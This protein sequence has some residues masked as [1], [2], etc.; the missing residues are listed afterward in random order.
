MGKT[1]TFDPSRYI[2]KKYNRYTV[3]KYDHMKKYGKTKAHFFKCKCD[4]GNER[5]VRITTLT[6]N[7][8]KSC[9]CL[10]REVVAKNNKVNVTH[11]R[12]N[13]KLYRVY[14]AMKSRCNDPN[15]DKY[16]VY[17]GR[18]IRVC[19]EWENSFE[20]FYKWAIANG[21][22]E[23]VSIDRIDPNGNYEPGN[24]RWLNQIEQCRN[25]RNNV[26]L[27]HNGKKQTAIEWAEELGIKHSTILYRHRNGWSDKETLTIPVGGKR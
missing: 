26:V 3:V 22:K 11:G 14:H 16:K 17:G 12:S 6:S 15:H 1:R 7:Q 25:K 13:T 9:G 23:G 24:C 18:G 5:V 20:L 2:G 8:S 19:E 21:Y 10:Q 27:E 4:C